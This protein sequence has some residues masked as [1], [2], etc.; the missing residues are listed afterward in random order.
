MTDPTILTNLTFAAIASFIIERLKN[1]AWFPFVQQ[2]GTLIASR[3]L[4][5]ITAFA[6]ASGIH[7]AWSSDHTTLTLTNL[8]LATIGV[9]LWHWLGQFIVQE[10]W[11]QA[12]ISKK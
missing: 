12:V 4:A 2:E 5:A 11:Y 1:A 8:S 3:I 6:S 7:Y 9:A 10:G